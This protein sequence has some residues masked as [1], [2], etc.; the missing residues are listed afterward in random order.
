MPIFTGGTIT[1]VSGTRVHEFTTVGATNIQGWANGNISVLIVGGGGG[2]G[3]ATLSTPGGGGGGGELVNYTVE[4]FTDPYPVSVDVVIGAGGAVNTNGGNS[5]FN[6][7]SIGIRTANGGGK[8]AQSGGTP[9]NGGS[10][11]G[12]ARN[13][14]V[15]G[16]STKT[17]YGLGNAGGVSISGIVGA[18]GG[19]GASAVGSTVSTRDGSAGG[20]GY[21]DSRTGTTRQYCA[22]GGGGA[23]GGSGGAAGDNSAGKG[24]DV[25]DATNVTVNGG[26]AAANRGG[27]G[28]GAPG[29]ANVFGLAGEGGSG[30]VIVS[31]IPKLPTSGPIRFQMLNVMKKV[32]S[33]TQKSLSSVRSEYSGAP[34]SGAI[35]ISGLRTL[36]LVTV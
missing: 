27:G 16:T 29:G 28:G 23:R 31:Y 10:G 12:A 8:G 3:S 2:G 5:S 26:S 25:A 7:P 36:G 17:I 20:L 30:R 18:A 19:G 24:G 15:G 14:T 21:T 1:T 11:G 34:A 22:G 9:G 13:G 33:T 4:L 35:S 32:T 6:I